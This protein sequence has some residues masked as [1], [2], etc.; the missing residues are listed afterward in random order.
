MKKLK[1]EFCDGNGEQV[2]VAMSGS[3][4]KERLYQIINLFNT[5]DDHNPPAAS[6]VTKTAMAKILDLIKSQLSKSWFTSKDL[7]LMYMEQYH[8]SIKPSTVSTYL[9][10]LYNNGY[11]ERNGNRSCWQY[12]VVT[13]ISAKNVENIIKDLSKK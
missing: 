9:T 8:E 5:N 3:V 10:R 12:R 2:T 11:L 7:S 6:H 1:I 13:T 4:S